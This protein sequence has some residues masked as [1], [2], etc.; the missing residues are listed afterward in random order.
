MIPAVLSVIIAFSILASAVI[1]VTLT[2]FSVV[3]NTVK[4]QQ[5]F[6]I[7]EAGL[8]Y[9]LWHLNHNSTDYKDGQSTPTTPGTY[10][11]GPYVHQYIDTNGVNE[12]TY[13]LYISPPAAG[14]TIA[15]VR[16][17]GTA[18]N[19]SISRTVQA[20]L[21]SPS[22][23]SYGVVSD[24]ALWFGNTE[25]A[26]GPVF[27]NQGVRMDGANTS[28]VSSANSSYVPSVELGGDGSTSE[29]GVW[30]NTSVTSPVNCN[31]RSKSDWIYPTSSIDFNQISSSLCTMKKVAFGDYS[32]TSSLN[33]GSNPCSQVPNTRT[34]AYIP[35]LSSS[36]STTKGYL[37]ILN[38]NGTYD[39]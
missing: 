29:N 24:S 23:A 11:Y 37:I 19:S 22:F 15:T 26:D 17:I 33:N 36:F 31:T 6:N 39:L 8:N 5:A 2:N 30:C 4:S 38:T 14:S 9:Y 3:A 28:T 16:S 18:A 10:G 35:E 25:T 27:S 12:G 20:Q 13:T 1:E 32:S 21:G 34:N 7:A